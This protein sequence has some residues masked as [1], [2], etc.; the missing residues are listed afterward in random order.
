LDWCERSFGP[1][2]AGAG[3]AAAPVTVAA[4]ATTLTKPLGVAVFTG[5]RDKALEAAMTAAGWEIAP[6]VTNT[7]TVLII[8]DDDAKPSTKIA[9]AKKKGIEICKLS[10]FRSRV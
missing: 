3:A 9:A 1:A 6:S 2:A 4:R 8:A 5:V 7:T 10:D